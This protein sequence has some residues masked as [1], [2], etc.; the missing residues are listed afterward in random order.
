MRCKAEKKLHKS[1]IEG[2]GGSAKGKRKTPEMLYFQGFSVADPKG[3]EPLTFWSVGESLCLHL[4][5]NAC[6]YRGFRADAFIF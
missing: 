4:L 2:T 3:F 1:C 5:E 6:I